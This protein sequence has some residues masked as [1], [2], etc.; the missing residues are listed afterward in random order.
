MVIAFDLLDAPAS[1]RHWWLV[2]SDGQ[3]DICLKHP[4]HAVD[5]TVASR[6]QT[7]AGV[8]L[9]HE[10]PRVAVRSGSIHL[11]GLSA[12]IRGFQRWCPRSRLAQVARA[13]NL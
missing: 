12:L 9:G 1:R 4:G 11:A 2:A 7:L 5:V 10:E 6:M 8:W 13:G 3:V